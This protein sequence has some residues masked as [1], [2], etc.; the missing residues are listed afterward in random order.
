MASGHV[1]G[2]PGSVEHLYRF[3]LLTPWHDTHTQ[4]DIRVR[5]QFI[6]LLLQTVKSLLIIVFVQTVDIETVRFES[7]RDAVSFF[8]HS[9]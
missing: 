2:R 3:E 8:R 1:A 5:C 7:S 4:T 6:E 9:R